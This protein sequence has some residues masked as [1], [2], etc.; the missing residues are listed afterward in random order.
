MLN[1]ADNVRCDSLATCVPS[2]GFPRYLPMYFLNHFFQW[3]RVRP[4]GVDRYGDPGIYAIDTDRIAEEIGLEEEA[5]RLGMAD[6]PAA[7]DKAL[8]GVESL[9]VRRVEKARQDYLSWGADQ[10]KFLNQEIERRDIT[11]LLNKAGQLDKEFERKASSLLAEKEQVLG[12]LAAGAGH[13]EAEL[14]DFKARHRLFRQAG[15]PDRAGTFFRFS[16]LVLLVVVEGALNAV[17]FAK[18]ISTGL[19]GGFVYAGCFAFGNVVFAYLWGRWVLPNFNH[20]NP[21]RKLLGILA[22]PAALATALAVGLL[23]AHFRDALTVDL[24]DAPRAALESLR[25]NPLGLQEVHSWILFGVS[26]LFALIALGDSYGL[27]DPYPGYGAADRRRNQAFDDYL[28]ELE[29]VRKELQ[30]LKDESLAELDRALAES[31]TALHALHQT[32]EHKQAVETRLRNAVADV[33]NC[34]D[35]LLRSFRDSNKLHRKS[36]SP[37]YFSERPGLAELRWP[38]FALER[39][40]RKYAEQAAL[41]AGFVERI[42]AMRGNIQSSFVRHRDGLKPLDAHFEASLEAVS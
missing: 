12:E 2:D 3:L 25:Q 36:P 16:L 29:D 34:L 28:L 23:I 42:E 27:D 14:Q 38:D 9:I 11:P 8:T 4:R 37:A 19:V 41:M 20:R 33:D 18:G 24:E 39:D 13:A 31:R 17:F 6:L 40:R 10:L 30:D 5:R 22:A 26:L 7:D 15:Y 1:T 21:A 32:I 35:T